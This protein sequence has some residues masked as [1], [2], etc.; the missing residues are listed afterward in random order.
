MSDNVTGLADPDT[1]DVDLMISATGGPSGGTA[2][3][4]NYSPNHYA[5]FYVV[6]ALL[7]LWGIG[8]VFRH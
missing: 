2:W 3:H 5:W 7:L 8:G 4:T 6:G 1:T